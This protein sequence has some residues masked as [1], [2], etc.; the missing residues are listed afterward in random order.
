MRCKNGRGALLFLCKKEEGG[1]I[2]YKV[3]E[4]GEDGTDKEG[5]VKSIT[6]NLRYDIR[7]QMDV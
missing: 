4:R 5:E 1:N 7:V 2:S 6:I 3:V